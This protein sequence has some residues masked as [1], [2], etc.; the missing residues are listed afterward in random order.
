MPTME[1]IDESDVPKRRTVTMEDIDAHSAESVES[2]MDKHLQ[3]LKANGAIA[4]VTE[5]GSRLGRA[6]CC[7]NF[8][9]FFSGNNWRHRA[10]LKD[11]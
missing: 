4:A 10:L 11:L 5:D 9:V 1:D 8:R 6:V 7:Q 3:L 2:T